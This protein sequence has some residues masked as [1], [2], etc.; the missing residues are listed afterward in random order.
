M[1][2]NVQAR[3]NFITSFPVPSAAQEVEAH[4]I[5][6]TP[7]GNKKNNNDPNCSSFQ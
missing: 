2:K 1:T 3:F 6:F 7:E 4:P 5:P